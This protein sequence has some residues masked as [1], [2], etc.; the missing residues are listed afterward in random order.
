[1]PSVFASLRLLGAPLTVAYF[2]HLVLACVA[3][4]LVWHA[5]RCRADAALRNAILMTATFF[6]SPYVYDYDLAWLA[7]PAAWYVIYANQH[8]WRKLDREILVCAWLL[9]I[10]VANLHLIFPVPVGPLV[11]CALMYVFARRMP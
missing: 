9:P 1:M 7:F 5:W 10:A 8:G 4:A 11:L 3:A 6:A 2:A